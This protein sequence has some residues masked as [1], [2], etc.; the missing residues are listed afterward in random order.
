MT[1]RRSRTGWRALLLGA[2]LAPAGCGQT[3]GPANPNPRNTRVEPPPELVPPSDTSAPPAVSQCRPAGLTAVGIRS[4]HSEHDTCATAFLVD[5][6]VETNAPE[7]MVID[8]LAPY[9]ISRWTVQAAGG[10]TRHDFQL[11]WEPFGRGE[12]GAKPLRI[13]VCPGDGAA[14]VLACSQDGCAIYDDEEA[15]PRL[16]PPAMAV[17]FEAP[18]SYASMVTLEEGATRDVAVRYFV[19]RPQPGAEV[20]LGM[21]VASRYGTREIVVSPREHR[22]SLAAGDGV[23]TFQVHAQ[24]DDRER[25]SEGFWVN[26]TSSLSGGSGCVVE[27]ES[28]GLE[29]REAR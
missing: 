12:G 14:T 21:H 22:V 18:W 2:A 19:P 23:V 9:P 16:Q 10:V 25:Y 13:A 11:Y 5:F 24:P 3:I 26:W 7:T 27:P 1:G 8:M 17:S 15:V 4:A 29:V 28:F 20:T 6:S